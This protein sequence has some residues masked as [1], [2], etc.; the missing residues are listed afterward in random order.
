MA[1]AAELPVPSAIDTERVLLGTILVDPNQL[2][3]AVEILPPGRGTWFYQEA[4]RLI[5]DTMLT[6]MERGDAIDLETVTDVLRRRGSLDKVG[7][8]V[9]IAELMEC[10]VT[11][12]NIAHH[13]RI[14]RDKALYRGMINIGSDIS[15]SAYAQEDLPGL[16]N[17]MQEA[18][19]SVA[20]AQSTS[21]F[22]TLHDL[23]TDTIRNAQHADERDLTGIHTGFHG[24]N[25]ITSGFQNSNLI[26]VAARPSQGK[27]ALA[28][29]FA[30][31]AAQSLNG[32]PVAVFSLEMSR[33]ELGM[34]ILCS[35]AC[36]DS[37]CLKRG[38][39]DRAEW[40]L[41]FAASDRLDHLPM[42][43]DDTSSLSVLDVRTR[44]KR[45]QMEHG[46]GMVV[47]DYL[48]LMSSS[49]KRQENRQQ[50]VS[51]ISRDLKILAK[52]LNVPV[53]AL[54]QLSREVEHRSPPVPVLSDIRDSGAVEQ[55][56]D[57]VLFIYRGDIYEPNADVGAKLMVAK[58][59]NGPTGEVRLSFSQTFARFDDRVH[60]YQPRLAPQRIA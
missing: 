34:R 5:Y 38:F 37:A 49:G 13:A 2:M 6:L 52:D 60:D 24:L 12:A 17:R 25:T 54:S 44:A 28:L 26:I 55:D 7:G 41:I 16:I 14:V 35:E 11:T 29:Q 27:S 57:V 36:V 18:L 9:Y 22:S 21:A 47:I 30:L 23:M 56:A 50:E 32:L 59:R 8:S 46:L 20:G 45:L 31:A 48:Q 53:I 40:G 19:L 10:V 58:Q 42:L 51:D 1:R 15:A 4:H 43:I 3:T 33:E 39:L